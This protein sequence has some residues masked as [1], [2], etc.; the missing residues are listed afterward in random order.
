MNYSDYIDYYNGRIA[1]HNEKLSS[2]AGAMIDT[3]LQKGDLFLA[4]VHFP[5]EAACLGR[6]FP[7]KNGKATGMVYY[8]FLPKNAKDPVIP[9]NI[10]TTKDIRMGTVPEAYIAA[11]ELAQRNALL[12]RFYSESIGLWHCPFNPLIRPFQKAQ[13]SLTNRAIIYNLL[14]QFYIRSTALRSEIE[15]EFHERL[16]RPIY[17]PGQSG[18]FHSGRRPIWLHAMN[19]AMIV[20]ANSSAE[21]QRGIKAGIIDGVD[22]TS[23]Y[24]FDVREL[25]PMM[26]AIRGYFDHRSTMNPG[27]CPRIGTASELLKLTVN[28]FRS[29]PN[30]NRQIEAQ[31]TTITPA[32]QDRQAWLYGYGV[33]QIPRHCL[34]IDQQKAL[35]AVMA[36]AEMSRLSHRLLETIA[37]DPGKKEQ[38]LAPRHVNGTQYPAPSVWQGRNNSKIHLRENTKKMQN[39]KRIPTNQI[40]YQNLA[41]INIA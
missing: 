13:H 2:R 41:D 4:G 17:H 27:D 12:H 39:R 8:D 6:R 24:A 23:W 10:Q 11:G 9:D 36:H 28:E 34:M 14:N 7:W 29:K 25:G 26:Q 22:K 31:L 30:L 19:S 18:D 1:E 32:D 3:I 21:V 35:N 40:V 5:N 33:A 38:F 37:L 15:Y 20:Y 16:Q